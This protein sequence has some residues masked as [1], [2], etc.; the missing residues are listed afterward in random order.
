MSD[1]LFFSAMRFVWQADFAVYHDFKT[2]CRLFSSNRSSKNQAIP[3]MEEETSDLQLIQSPDKIYV[4][5]QN[6]QWVL[7]KNFPS[8]KNVKN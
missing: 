7:F 2:A 5:A 8:L 1:C 4:Q 3:D 6:S